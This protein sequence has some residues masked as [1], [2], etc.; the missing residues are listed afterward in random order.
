MA[1]SSPQSIAPRASWFLSLV[2]IYEYEYES[3]D[4][5]AGAPLLAR[6]LKEDAPLQI[7]AS[8]SSSSASNSDPKSDSV[9]KY[10]RLLQ[11]QASPPPNYDLNV[12]ATTMLNPRNDLRSE[13]F[14]TDDSSIFDELT[15]ALS[16]Q[17][18]TDSINESPSVE[19][20]STSLEQILKADKDGFIHPF[21]NSKT[22]NFASTRELLD[23]SQLKSNLNRCITRLEQLKGHGDE[24]RRG[25]HHQERRGKI[26]SIPTRCGLGVAGGD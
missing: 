18:I 4:R 14:L 9:S 24:R 10:R 1:Q 22:T 15:S 6:S 8:H 23:A 16:K 26:A 5:T 11:A 25:S 7:P 3:T 12:M 20:N 21:G 19:R 13:P 17:A 2:F